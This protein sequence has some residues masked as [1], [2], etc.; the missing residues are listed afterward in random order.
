M[1]VLGE[2]FLFYGL[3][4]QNLL[5]AATLKRN[6]PFSMKISLSTYSLLNIYKLLQNTAQDVDG[7][8]IFF[9]FVS[10]LISNRCL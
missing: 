6:A 7:R 4:R 5:F 3:R 8:A 2:L 1:Q 10:L 9:E